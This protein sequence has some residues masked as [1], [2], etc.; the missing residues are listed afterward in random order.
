[1]RHSVS[2]KF[3]WSDL[4]LPERARR[5]AAN[6]FDDVELW[7]WRDED[8]DGLAEACRESG[9]GIAGFFG[10]SSAA[11]LDP[12]QRDRLLELLAE[13]VAV[14]E[15]VGARQL[16][17]FS[18]DRGPDGFRKHPPLTDAAKRRSC[19]EGLRECVSLVEGKPLELVV[20]AIN[21]VYVPG[22]F[23]RDSGAA[24]ELCR[25]I[26]HPQVTMFF[27]CYHQQLAGGRL[28]ENLVE[29]L[30]WVAS[31]HIADVPGRHQ[32]GTGE[33]NFTSI[34]RVL[35]R[36]GYDRQLTFEVVPLDGKSEAAV[37]AI[38]EIFPF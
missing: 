8:I 6:G 22:Y 29:A 3:M 33:I 25:E 24:L 9:I 38:K 2:I 27:D 15:R 32:P 12:S 20:E 17:M 35:E 34:R 5:A 11:L 7:D 18:D 26:D 23:L 19:V 16:H 21:G 30:P 14:A 13:T 37:E 10:H 31:V 36:Q 28:I 1:V 4:P